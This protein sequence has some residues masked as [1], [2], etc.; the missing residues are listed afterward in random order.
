MRSSCVSSWLWISRSVS[1]IASE[2]AVSVDVEIEL[3]LERTA[4]DRTR[5]ELR[6]VH[7]APRE[8]DDDLAQ[9]A[10]LVRRH[11]HQR[12]LAGNVGRTGRRLARHLDEAG[13]VALL[14]LDRARQ[15]LEAERAPGRLARDRRQRAVVRLAHLAR[16]ARGVELGLRLEPRALAQELLALEQ[17]LR[18][19]HHG[20]EVFDPRAGERE[21]AVL[22]LAH[23]FG[24]DGEPAFGQ[25]V[26]GLVDAA[27]G[28]VLDR[29][30]S[31]VDG[32][33][34]HRFG[35][36]ADGLVAGEHHAALLILVVALRG[37]MAVRAFDPLVGDAQRRR[38]QVADVG[39]LA[40]DRHLEN[41]PVQP[42]DLVRVEVALGRQV[43]DAQEELFLALL[44][45]ER[46][47]IVD[48]VDRD[49]LRQRHAPAEHARGSRG[50]SPPSPRAGLAG[51]ACPLSRRPRSSGRV[52]RRG[53]GAFRGADA[54]VH[55][56]R[57]HGYRCKLRRARCSTEWEGGRGNVERRGA[58]RV[59]PRCGSGCTATSSRA[60]RSSTTSRPPG[61]S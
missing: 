59:E 45:A 18:V 42:F 6:E 34:E 31:D 5:L 10:R 54:G 49:L 2:A 51:H 46:K 60:S 36:G 57:A 22:D 53:I 17:R 28:R 39:V 40:G 56:C 23:H 20:A 24:V 9:R 30:E 58:L 4:R 48:L 47:R 32:A 37:E 16:R 38:L 33:V 8:R 21:Q 13:V 35:G 15:H 26:V 12:R 50:R 61:C 41:Q 55:P 11:Q 14:G 19:R 44:V 29:Q 3:V 1:V 27:R 7:P 43:A 52:Y 25:L